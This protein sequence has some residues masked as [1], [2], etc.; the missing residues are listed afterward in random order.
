MDK[1]SIIIRCKNDLR[2]FD[3]IKS[4]D[5]PAEVIVV[6]V[7]NEEIKKRLL[8]L[9]VTVLDAPDNNTGV[10]NNIG[11]KNASN[12]CCLIMDSDSIFGEGYIEKCYD[13]INNGYDIARGKI[14]FDFI[15]N[16]FISEVIAKTRDYFNNALQ[17]PYSPGLAIRKSAANRIGGFNE[18]IRWST[19][20]EFSRRFIDNGAKYMFIDDVFVK[21]SPI[22][23]K[24]D[25]KAAYRTGI[26][27]KDMHIY[28]AIILKGFL[29]NRFKSILFSYKYE[30]YKSIYSIYGFSVMLYHF[31][32]VCAFNWGYWS[33]QK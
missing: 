9:G 18:K 15:K 31:L 5:C 22:T 8:N 7:P 23:F 3:T 21:H 29:N 17:L 33:S 12:E 19:D 11:L 13:S 10:S 32:W 16:S 30:P 24:H 28:N 27:T 1:I 6:L 4:I 25:L 2:I 20:D 14:V 26:A